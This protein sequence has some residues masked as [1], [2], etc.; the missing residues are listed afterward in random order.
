[1]Q[2]TKSTVGHPCTGDQSAFSDVVVFN[3]IGKGWGVFSTGIYDCNRKSRKETENE[4]NALF[5]EWKQNGVP[6]DVFSVLK[7]MKSSILSKYPILNLKNGQ[8]NNFGQSSN[9]ERNTV[10]F[11][12]KQLC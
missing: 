10:P 12:I 9:R 7:K 2:I 4:A 8:R 11:N 3:L 1:M 6:Q 5:N